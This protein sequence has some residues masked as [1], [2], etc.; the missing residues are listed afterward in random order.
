MLVP[1]LDPVRPA[2]RS[3]IVVDLLRKK[4]GFSGLIISDDLDLK[5]TMRGDSIEDTAVDSLRAGVDLLLLSAGPQVDD[6][7]AEIVEAV[8]DGRVSRARLTEAADAVR[9][10]A[11]DLP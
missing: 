7:A 2:S 10:F 9:R 1:A 3:T 6:V 4:F 5:G 11:A 8:A